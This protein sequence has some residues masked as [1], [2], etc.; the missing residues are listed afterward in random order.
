MAAM[1]ASGDGPAAVGAATAGPGARTAVGG[2]EHDLS[3]MPRSEHPLPQF[4]RSE[5]RNL[6]GRW[7]F[8][9]D[10]GKSGAE[11]GLPA[12]RGFDRAIL[13]PFCPESALSGVGHSDFIEAMWYHRT[14][15]IPTE[16]AGKGVMLHF[17]GVDWMCEAWVDGVFVGRH[18]GG[19]APFA[20]DIAAHVRP[21]ESHH[22]VLHVRDDVRSRVQPAGKQCPWYKSRGCE[23]S[24]VTGIWQTVWLEAV[25]PDGL[26]GCHVLADFDNGRLIV[27]PTFRRIGR[28]QVWR[29]TAFAAGEPVASA[30]AFAASGVALH[31]DLPQPRAWSPDDPFLYRLVY[32][33]LDAGGTVVDRVASYA[34]LRKVHIEGNRVFLNNQPL[35][36]RLVLEQ[37]YF[38]DG[39]WTAP[40]EE[41][42][43]R[44]IRLAQGF[45]FN[46]ARL[47]QKIF[48]ARY[49]Y[50]ADRL[51]YL[52]WVEGPIFLTDVGSPLLARNF[53][54]EWR[55]IVVRLRNHPSIITW[56]P[57]NETW[58]LS[59]RE[60]EHKR[61]VLDAYQL[62]RSLDPTRPVNDAS[63][64]IHVAS[65]LYTVHNYEE[66]PETLHQML[67][68]SGDV[69]V[70]RPH[71]DRED[72]YAG[73]PYIVD[74]FG[75][76]KW[77]PP[78]RRPYADNSWGYGDPPRTFEE[79]YARLRGLV[80]AVR[81]VPNVV[82]FCYTQLTDVE[83]EENG[84]LTYAREHKFDPAIIR[85]AITQD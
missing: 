39:I 76:I 53:L 71:G 34:G 10:P 9:F 43:A 84:L 47:H 27:I 5:W 59:D 24:R 56:V 51:G 8:A 23:Y 30:R 16:W 1:D 52:T 20:F 7:T 64:G 38:P 75:G 31:L 25:A 18:F 60:A 80:R 2:I 6:N 69:P 28:G 70:W 55:E 74:E 73:Q 41:A 49:L 72:P 63:G 15:S 13:V 57:F 22:L 62:T 54:S 58:T 33:V 29:V 4:E 17:G 14:I 32:E 35:Y 77:I 36:Q 68:G 79:F 61:L 45:G 50:W 82:G 26:D 67:R 12:S 85:A 65:D 44:D 37:G 81:S 83:Q 66:D 21:G 78:G 11:R 48:E 19:S 42:F 46:G 3:E 40:S